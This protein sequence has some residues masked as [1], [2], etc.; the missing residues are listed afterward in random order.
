[1][2]PKV[3]AHRGACFEAPE[4]T[5]SAFKAAFDLGADGFE[6]D[7]QVTKDGIPVIQHNYSID[8]NSDGKG[9]VSEMTLEELRGYDF[10]SWFDERFANEKI[11]TLEE[12]IDFGKKFRT[13]NIEIKAP[14]HRAKH[15]VLPIA[16]MIASSGY[17]ERIIVS[18][19]DHSILK[20]AKNAYP[21]LHIGALV[22]SGMIAYGTI[23]GRCLP[24]D[25]ELGSI[26]LKDASIP[27][28]I[29]E[30]GSLGMSKDDMRRWAVN[31]V[32]SLCMTYPW[33][34]V[35]E[36]AEAAR[37]QSD[38]CAYA[39]DIGFPLN[40]IHCDYPMCLKD[41]DLVR[42]LHDIGIGVN[43]WTPDDEDILKELVAMGPDGI[44]TNRP[45]IL[46]RILKGP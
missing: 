9:M 6:T 44:I 33:M 37:R 35:K 21:D 10:G 36:L 24:G 4:N 17:S 14:P 22:S 41:P 2:L 11:A 29:A 13:I 16:E 46:L 25:R 42:R 43:I 20:D 15:S 3:I 8:W 1:M 7:V 34:T 12:C 27:E 32:N 28:D 39:E 23:L 40:Y 38:L 19:F 26:T 5:M 31:T 45:D 18:S 30:T